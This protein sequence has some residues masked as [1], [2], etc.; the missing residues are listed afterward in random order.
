MKRLRRRCISCMQK[1]AMAAQKPP[2]GGMR[3]TLKRIKGN[4]YECVLCK[5]RQ[6]VKGLRA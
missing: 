2:R 1:C 3:Y 5:T 6:T 4:I